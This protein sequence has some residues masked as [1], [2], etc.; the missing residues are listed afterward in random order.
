MYVKL[1]GQG[2]PDR[3]YQTGGDHIEYGSVP[4]W[5]PD[6]SQAPS[7]ELMDAIGMGADVIDRTLISSDPYGYKDGDQARPFWKLRW[8][9]FQQVGTEEIKLVICTGPI[10]IMGDNGKTI[11]KVAY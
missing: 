7:D 5:K 3:L 4:W 10:Y 6:P 8:A 1:I 11:E 2:S 9:R